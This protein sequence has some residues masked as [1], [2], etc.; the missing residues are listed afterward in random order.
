MLRVVIVIHFVWDFR[1]LMRS[2]E[3]DKDSPNQ[4]GTR[5]VRQQIGQDVSMID[6]L[7]NLAVAFRLQRGD[8]DE[9]VLVSECQPSL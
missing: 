5:L 9:N 8:G 6:G 7:A 3:N 1:D 2:Q 4:E